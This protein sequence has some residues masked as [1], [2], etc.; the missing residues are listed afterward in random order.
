MDGALHHQ[1]ITC[2]IYLSLLHFLITYRVKLA[3]ATL[4][5]VLMDTLMPGASSKDWVP[6]SLTELELAHGHAMAA[7]GP[8]ASSP[9][10]SHNHNPCES[11]IHNPCESDDHNPCM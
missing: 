2:Q 8:I 6:M 5:Q 9:C 1:F 10:E 3:L 4:E 7:Y 11:Y